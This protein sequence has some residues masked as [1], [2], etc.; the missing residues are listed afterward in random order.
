MPNGLLQSERMRKGLAVVALAF[1]PT[2]A[3]WIQVAANDLPSEEQPVAEAGKHWAFIPPRRAPLPPASSAGNPIDALLSAERARRGL[4]AVEPADRRTLLRRLHLD[5]VGLPPT[6]AEQATFLADE[7]LDAYEREVERLLASPR[8]GE[9]WGRH[10]MDVWRYT[11]WYGLG[12]QLR[13]SQKHI[14]RW[15]DWIVRSIGEDRGY[16]RMILEMLAADELFPT[17]RH[18]LAATGFLA[19][20]YF[21]FNRTTWLDTT[22][23]HTA[24]A[25]LGLTV[26]CAKCHDHKYDP[27]TQ[28]DYYRMRAFFEPHQVRLD[29]V[30]GE[31]DLEKDGLPRVFDAHLEAPTYVHIR[32]DAK[33]PDK[34]RVIEPGVPDLLAFRRLEFSTVSLPPEAH[35]PALQ[36]FVLEDQLRDAEKAIASAGAAH[37]KARRQLESSREAVRELSP[38]AELVRPKGDAGDAA[39]SPS[40]EEAQLAVTVAA[41]TL[42]AAELRPAAFRHA[43][44]AD[45]VRKRKNPTAADETDELVRQAALAARELELAQAEEGLARAEQKLAAATPE[46]K[47]A[48]TKERDTARKKLDGTR[49]ALSEPGEAYTSLRASLKALEGPDE[50]NASRRQPYPKTS[51]GRRTALARWIVD[52]RNPLT[53]R[54]AVNHIWLRHL[55]RPLVESV[56]DFG[57]RSPPPPQQ[58]LLDWLAVELVESGWSMKHLHRLIV[59][60]DAYR[61]KSSTL[62]ADEATRSADPANIYY[63]R[64]EPT[65]MESQVLRDSLL[66]L[67]EALDLRLGGP[68]IDPGKNADKSLRRSLYFT[69]SR[70]HRHAFLAMFDD[71]DILACYRR[72]ESIVP[73]QALALSNS[74]L[75][76]GMARRIAGVVGARLEREGE[77]AS[78]AAFA[79][80]A[81]ETVL[82]R[83][84]TDAELQ[85]C[86]RTLVALTDFLGKE[87]RAR[88]R[89]DLV[90]ALV[91]HNDFVTIR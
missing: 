51:T 63:W 6:A 58:A 52:P 56:T 24:K 48:T 11:D 83:R 35:I 91:N 31:T 16:D 26:N 72:S 8:H 78:D 37:R 50:K 28:V 19:R 30:P 76:L 5:L 64:R 46:K 79:R 74:K 49:Q 12:Q 40:V 62:G 38:D 57:T 4:R 80:A 32:G 27:I 85:E 22:I 84:P 9:R 89:E 81:F 15:R 23:E 82:A 61:L 7:R 17:D 59:C 2:V 69:H 36:S 39:R 33:Q 47:E 14:W 73:Q 20:N 70:D 54:V 21:L 75:A 1:I 44:A 13:Y 43:H 71:A 29:A 88:A 25:F 90:H 34:S 66:H 77:S 10:W 42:K 53:A 60:S 55:G 65:R 3:A 67:A 45:R 68:T 41:L 86:L 18:A 87:K